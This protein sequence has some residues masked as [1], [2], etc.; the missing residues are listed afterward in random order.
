[1]RLFLRSDLTSNEYM[2]IGLNDCWITVLNYYLLQGAYNST[3]KKNAAISNVAV[4]FFSTNFGRCH[5]RHHTYIH[6][7]I[8]GL[9]NKN[10]SWC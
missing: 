1:M 9:F 4:F 2:S 5:V 10:E 8:N 6:R 3:E 7:S